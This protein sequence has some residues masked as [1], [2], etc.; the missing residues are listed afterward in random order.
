VLSIT[1]RWM[2]ADTSSSISATTSAYRALTCQTRWMRRCGLASCGTR[3]QT[4]PEPLAT[5][6]AAARLIISAGSSVTSAGSPASPA[7]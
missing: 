7:R 2:P 1:S 4:M 3:V 5:S 6:I